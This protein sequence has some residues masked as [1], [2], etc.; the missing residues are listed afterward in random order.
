MTT[1]P[2][3]P[4]YVNYD[5]WNEVFV[6]LM[7][8]FDISDT[9]KSGVKIEDAY[10]AFSHHSY[11]PLYPRVLDFNNT[12]IHCRNVEEVITAIKLINKSKMFSL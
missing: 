5:I 6:H 2:K 4:D 12:D 7:K 3:A 9:F 1:L 8:E 10:V 11:G